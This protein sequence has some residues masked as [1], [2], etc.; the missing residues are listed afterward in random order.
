MSVNELGNKGSDAIEERV[1]KVWIDVLKLTT[2]NVDR[3]ATFIEMGGDSI[4]AVLCMTRL[5]GEFGPDLDVDISD[6]F[7]TRSTI[8]NFADGILKNNSTELN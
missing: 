4:A 1:A 5:R 3:N 2:D 7:D 6:F 8:M